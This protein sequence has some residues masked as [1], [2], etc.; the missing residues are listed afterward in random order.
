[1]IGTA[2]GSVTCPLGETD[3]GRYC[4]NLMTDAFNCGTCGVPCAPD[5]ACSGGVCGCLAG[6]TDC[7]GTCDNLNSDP[8]NCGACNVACFE[9]LIGDAT[10]ENGQCN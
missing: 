6:L 10:C 9:P 3:C 8:N 7:Y 2:R 4:A 1:M 5:R